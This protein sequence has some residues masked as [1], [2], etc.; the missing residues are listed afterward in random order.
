MLSLSDIDL[1]AL[2]TNG[3]ADRV[4]GS[5]DILTQTHS[6][7]AATL[8]GGF[9][10]PKTDTLQIANPAGKKALISMVYSIDGVNYYPQ[11]YRLYQPG[12]PPPSGRLIAVAGAAVDEDFI[13]FYFTHYSGSTVNYTM[14]YVLDNIL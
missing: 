12:N 3:S 8:S 11:R 14:K 9:Y 4:I 6:V 13:T 10:L 2:L 1:L 7:G 5:F